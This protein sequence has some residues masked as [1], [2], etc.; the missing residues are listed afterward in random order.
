MRLRRSLAR[1][2]AGAAA[3][4]VVAPFMAACGNSSTTS[5][6]SSPRTVTVS[7]TPITPSPSAA[8]VP[9][10]GDHSSPAAAVTG[11][12][13]ALTAFDGSD[14]A[15]LLQW[16]APSQ[17]AAYAASLQSLAGRKVSL[18]IDGFRITDIAFAGNSPDIAEVTVSGT[19]VLCTGGGAGQ[20]ASTCS[21]S[22][23][24]PGQG[25]S[26]LLCQRE[27]GFWYVALPA[28]ATPSPSARAT[29]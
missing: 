19:A 14:P 29:P 2:C 23:I 22:A 26:R 4:A 15:P 7:P 6:A 27:G 9:P 11:F 3:A 8:G 1:V 10:Q 20:P 17:R 21:P 5:G 12:V 13:Q 24:G 18:R 28:A 16:I 25:G